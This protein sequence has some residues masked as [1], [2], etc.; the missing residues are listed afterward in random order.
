[1]LEW[2]GDGGKGGQRRK[3]KRKSERSGGE[4][5]EMSARHLHKWQDHVRSS[6]V[7]IYEGTLPASHETTKEHQNQN[8]TEKAHKQK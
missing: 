5:G 7:R 2:A 6:F 3:E 1:M 4:L 8:G